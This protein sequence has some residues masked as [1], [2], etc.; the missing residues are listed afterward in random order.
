M[1][2]YL[3]RERLRTKSEAQKK[4]EN[5]IGAVSI[6]GGLAGA[7]AAI[8]LEAAGVIHASSNKPALEQHGGH[9]L[10]VDSSSNL[11]KFSHEHGL[12]INSK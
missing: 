12:K 10:G 5:T 1:S 2:D 4:I 11:N 6:I 7:G 8:G 9:Q 3:Q